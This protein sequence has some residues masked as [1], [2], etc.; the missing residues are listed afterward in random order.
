MSRYRDTRG[1]STATDRTEPA[2]PET[3]PEYE[4]GFIAYCACNHI[5]AAHDG[6]G[7]SGPCYYCGCL[8][9]RDYDE[10]ESEARP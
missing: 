10:A 9:F 1:R 2:P 8:R 3:P 5:R 7:F 6:T 4:A